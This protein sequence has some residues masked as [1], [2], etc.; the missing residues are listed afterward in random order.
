MTSHPLTHHD[1]LSL[2]EP[3]SRRGRHVDLLAS[4]RVERRLLFRPIEHRDQATSSLN[5]RETLQLDNP[6]PGTFVLTRTLRL[7]SGLR[8]LLQATG[9]HPG[10][11]LARIETIP[12]PSQFRSGPGF[13]IAHSHQ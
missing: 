1:I 13:L 5:L 7:A 6:E 3:F 12:L 11:L 4:N 8:A 2:V 9:P 10:E